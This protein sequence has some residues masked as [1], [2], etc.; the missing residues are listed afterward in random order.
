MIVKSKVL[1][2]I[3]IFIAC[4]YVVVTLIVYRMALKSNTNDDLILREDNWHFD[5]DQ[6]P[7]QQQ[8]QKIKQMSTHEFV[9]DRGNSNR[10]EKRIRER[11][12]NIPDFGIKH[13]LNNSLQ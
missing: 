8:L 6:Q 13:A 2:I 12:R 9:M 5:H 10:N 1:S 4:L 7:N 11:K 3:I